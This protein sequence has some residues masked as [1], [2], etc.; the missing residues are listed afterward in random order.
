MRLWVTKELLKLSQPGSET[1]LRDIL[2]FQV[3]TGVNQEFI[4]PRGGGGD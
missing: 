2:V 3:V 4:D 1:A